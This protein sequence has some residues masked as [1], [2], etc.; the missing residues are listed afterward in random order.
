[1]SKLSLPPCGYYA[2]EQ[3]TC[4]WGYCADG[5]TFKSKSECQSVA[6]GNP[7]IWCNGYPGTSGGCPPEPK[8]KVTLEGYQAPCCRPTAYVHLNETWNDQKPFTL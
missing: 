7:G 2:N 3:G 4:E 1:M 6:P 8:P 5:Q